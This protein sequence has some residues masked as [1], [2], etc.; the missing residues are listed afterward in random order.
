MLKG[1]QDSNWLGPR[2]CAYCKHMAD[3]RKKWY[4]KSVWRHGD[5]K[6]GE[7]TLDG[8]INNFKFIYTN[9]K[10]LRIQSRKHMAAN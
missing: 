3:S 5:K 9:K 7:W 2:L 6:N 8:K 10:Y 1:M 4:T